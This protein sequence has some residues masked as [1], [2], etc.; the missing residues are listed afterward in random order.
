MLDV[1]RAMQTVE[2]NYFDAFAD[3]STWNCFRLSAGG[4]LAPVDLAILDGTGLL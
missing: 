4:V 1:L 2:G 3:D